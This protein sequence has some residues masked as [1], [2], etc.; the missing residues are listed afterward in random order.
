MR[1]IVTFLESRDVFV[2][3][4]LLWVTWLMACRLVQKTK[5][6]LLVILFNALELYLGPRTLVRGAKHI[7]FGRGVCAR[8]NLWLEA[9]TSYGEEAFDPVIEIGD[10]VSFSDGVH[11]S[12]VQRI[13]IKRHVLVGSRVYIS[14]SG[15]GLYNGHEQSQPDA[16][17]RRRLARGGP[18]VIGENVCICANVIILGPVTIGDG[19]VICANSVIR[20]DVPPRTIVA[21]MPAVPV[22]EFREAT[23]CWE[24]V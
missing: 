10:G 8:S 23:N 20:R 15:H 4:P 6:L 11:I 22:K 7:S 2:S 21:G 17:S 16:P 24:R 1:K 14:D 18:V 5:S 19:A 9:V 12:C 13:V 3:D